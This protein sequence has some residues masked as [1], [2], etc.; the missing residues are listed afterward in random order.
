MPMPE[1]WSL[2]RI[3]YRIGF[4]EGGALGNEEYDAGPGRRFRQADPCGIE[5]TLSR[6]F[7]GNYLEDEQLPVA[8]RLR[9]F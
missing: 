4:L 2:A 8:R 3:G 1:Y 7:T 5:V 6:G 9:A